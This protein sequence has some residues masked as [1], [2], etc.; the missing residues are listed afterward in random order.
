[1]LIIRRAVNTLASDNKNVATT[2]QGF[3]NSQN[4]F[5]SSKKNTLKYDSAGRVTSKSLELVNKSSDSLNS[6]TETMTYDV[7]C[8]LL[9]ITNI[10]AQGKKSITKIDTT[11]GFV[12]N[13]K[14]PLG[15]IT[16]Y[17]Y[18]NLG[19]KLAVTDPSG[20]TTKWIYDD[21]NNK[22]TTKYSNSYEEYI[23]YNGFGEKIKTSDNLS[24]SERI[25]STK[26]Y[27]NLGQLAYS[28]GI[29]GQNSSLSYQY[30][31][32]G[33]LSSITD[34]LGNVRIYDYDSVAWTKTESFNNKVVNITDHYGSS[35]AQTNYSATPTDQPVKKISSYNIQGKEVS[36]I[37]GANHSQIGMR[38][39]LLMMILFN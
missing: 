9:T 31:N 12:T 3:V 14:D 4:V 37:L 15:K 8:P 19:R 24:G 36:S 11:T 6:T 34:A 30:N 23:Y 35:V 20:V 32:Q 39:N 10:N 1:M 33:E 13:S 26:R 22:I 17:T 5:E 29:L 2:T 25:L 38:V 18:D 28:E 7:A 21:V 16:D 27:N